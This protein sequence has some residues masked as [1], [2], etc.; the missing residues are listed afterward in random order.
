MI[1]HRYIRAST[2]ATVLARGNT[3]EFPLCLPTRNKTASPRT[4]QTATMRN[5]TISSNVRFTLIARYT[6]METDNRPLH[7]SGDVGVA[8][9]LGF[10]QNTTP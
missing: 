6:P 5:T 9:P 10:T 4:G 7:F 3:P 2:S 1:G 8:F